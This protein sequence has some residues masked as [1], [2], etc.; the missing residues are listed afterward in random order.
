MAQ[1][2]TFTDGANGSVSG[3]TTDQLTVTAASGNH[4]AI[5]SRYVAHGYS[6]SGSYSI[7]LS[8]DTGSGGSWNFDENEQNAGTWLENQGA[9]NLRTVQTSGKIFIDDT[10]G[11]RVRFQNES[12]SSGGKAYA[13]HGQQVK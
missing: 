13:L 5:H 7:M 9:G 2:D 11:L 10:V 6:A 4:V 8:R 1:G 12:C 3:D